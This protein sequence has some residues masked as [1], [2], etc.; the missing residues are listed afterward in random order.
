MHCD[1]LIAPGVLE[2]VATVCDVNKFDAEM[3]RGILK[4]AGLV[5]EFRSEKQQA[6]GWAI[7]FVR[8]ERQGLSTQTKDSVCGKDSLA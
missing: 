8:R 6:P 4:T 2:L 7:R 1:S 3:A 5:A